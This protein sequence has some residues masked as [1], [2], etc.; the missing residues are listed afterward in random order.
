LQKK[1]A[2]A[3]PTAAQELFDNLSSLIPPTDI[4][5]FTD[6]SVTRNLN[7]S[8]CA[9]FCPERNSAGS[10]RLTPGTSIFSAELQGIL[11]ALLAFYSLEPTP[12]HSHI[13]SDSRSAIKALLSPLFP[14][15]RCLNAIKNQIECLRSSGTATSLYWIPSHCGITRHERADKLASDEANSPT[16]SSIKNDLDPG[17][18]AS[19]CEK[20][21]VN[22][23]RSFQT[24]AV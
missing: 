3:N 14:K 12:E 16:G 17:E 6:G 7:N 8:S 21:W 2:L 19:I 4:K 18:L 9:Y 10:W 22:S 20:S 1:A 15:N 23:V 5:I 13:F 11:Q 24:K